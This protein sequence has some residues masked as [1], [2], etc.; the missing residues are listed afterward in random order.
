M[1][2]RKHHYI[3]QMIQRNFSDGKGQLHFAIRRGEA[4]RRGTSN[5]KNLFA[6]K[7]LY[8]IRRRDGT[9]IDDAE[10]IFAKMDDVGASFYRQVI[11][12]VRD[13]KIP[14][15]D[16]PVWMGWWKL[17]YFQQKRHPK[18][19]TPEY[20]VSARQ[21]A[22]RAQEHMSS[23]ELIAEGSDE[24]E[25]Q[26]Q[27]AV[28]RARLAQPGELL[29]PIHETLGLAIY[30]TDSSTASGLVLGSSITS[31]A[32]LGGRPEL[33]TNVTFM[34]IAPDIALG[35]HQGRREVII[36]EVNRRQV[37]LMNEAMARQSHTIAGPDDRQISILAKLLPRTL[38]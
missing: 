36:F 30:R 5:P 29:K 19:G 22:V 18:I 24:F 4:L 28:A 31:V 20:T 34:P 6:E 16:E 21:A 33:K 37:R 27:I 14:S 15:F 8:S 32:E 7:D 26:M 12:I 35:P 17:F 11:D 38:P 3:P 25:R 10:R 23:N 9:V 13:G 1:T 2:A